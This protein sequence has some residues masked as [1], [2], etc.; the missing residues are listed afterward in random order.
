M[1]GRIVRTDSFGSAV[2]AEMYDLFSSQFD[3][4]SPRQFERDLEDKN[5]VLLMRD[6]DERMVCFSSMRFYYSSI[7]GRNVALL[8]SGDTV[9]DSSTWGDSALSY[10]WMGA[11]DWLRRR[12]KTNKLY[13]FLIVS[14]YRTYRFL[15]VY[16]EYFFP[17]FDERTPADIQLLMHSMG[18]ERFKEQYDPESGIVRLEAPAVLKGDFR[19]IPEHR[20]KDPHIAYFAERNPGHVDGDE[21]LCFAELSEDKLTRLGKRMWRK[22]RA[23]FPDGV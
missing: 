7:G 20:L 16:S 14:G 18:S 8:F 9:V 1:N 2:R 11:V 17:R 23:L 21:L 3:G 13:W 5:W 10:Y 12:Y 19:G 15:P 6:D 4:V 22:G